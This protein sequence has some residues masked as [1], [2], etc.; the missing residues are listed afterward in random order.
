[1]FN[2]RN[3][4]NR[5]LTNVVYQASQGRWNPEPP[6]SIGA[7]Q[8]QAMALIVEQKLVEGNDKQKHAEGSDEQQHADGNDKQKHAEGSDEQQHADGNDEQKHAEGSDEQQHADGN[9]EQKH[10]EANVTAVSFK[11]TVNSGY[12][13]CMWDIEARFSYPTENP[14]DNFDFTASAVARA[15]HGPVACRLFDLRHT[16]TVQGFSLTGKYLW[17]N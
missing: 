12:G 13:G 15:V 9:D 11:C 7:N 16:W 6:S 8:L 17:N 1:M 2:I 5:P 4:L 10:A 14:R 3:S